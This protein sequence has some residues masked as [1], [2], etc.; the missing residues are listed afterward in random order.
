MIGSMTERVVSAQEIAGLKSPYIQH[1]AGSLQ[2]SGLAPLPPSHL[3]PK[4]SVFVSTAED[5]KKALAAQQGLIIATENIL[6]SDVKPTGETAIF[7]TPSISAAMAVVLPLFD[8]KSKRFH[9]GIHPTAVIDPSASIESSAQ[10]GAYAVIGADTVIGKQ[11]RIGSHVVIENEVTIGDHCIFHPH[12]Y[13]A[14]QS[15]IGHRVEIHAHASIGSDGFGYVQAP[16]KKRYKIP[17]IGRVVLEDDVEIGANCTIDRATIF[18]TRIRR[19][20]KLDNLVHIAHNCELGEDCAFAAGFMMA[21]STKIGDRFMCGGDVVV[22]DHLE[23]T[24]DVLL[25]GRSGVTNDI[26]EPGAYAGFPLEPMR[27]SLRTLTNLTKLTE[28]R[29]QLADIKKKLGM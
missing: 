29:K 18:E 28:M 14:A 25:G 22:A 2:S 20:T 21:G 11:T 7:S 17:Q 12:V 16:D 5:L 6:T 3:R 24:N 10:I 23:I 8:K 9:Q 1:V 26:K 4:G 19:G 13:I 15:Q 27:D